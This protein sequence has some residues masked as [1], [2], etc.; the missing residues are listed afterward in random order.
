[1]TLIQILIGLGLEYFLG[2]LDR[3]RDFAWFDRYSRWFELR[4]SRHR[5]WDGPAG[6]VV[7]LLLPLLAL[8]AAAYLLGTVSPVLVF[9]L[10]I[11][12]FVYSLGTDVHTLLKR[13]L[14]ALEQGREEEARGLEEALGMEAETDQ[15]AEASSLEAILFRSHENIFAVLFWFLVL[16]MVGALLYRLAARLDDRYDGIHGGYAEAVR[17]LHRLLMWPSTRL[18]ALGFGLSGSLVHALEYWR[19]VPGHSLDCSAAVVGRSGLGAMQ[20][21]PVGG[22][23]EGGRDYRE[24]IGEIQALINRTLIIWLTVLGVMTL[25]GWLG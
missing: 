9:L 21:Q 25:G 15:T 4:C 2:S 14:E 18:Q 6:V 22:E 23:E 5:Y 24:W 7:T 17:D 12:V 20:Y 10:G 1:M 11:A 19:E 13:Y 8:L 16:G 3:I